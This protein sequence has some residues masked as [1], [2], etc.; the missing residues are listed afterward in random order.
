MILGANSISAALDRFEHQILGDITQVR[1]LTWTKPC[2]VEFST[3]QL[4]EVDIKRLEERLPK[5]TRS[6]S[7]G[8]LYVFA[9]RQGFLIERSDIL[10]AFNYA[11]SGGGDKEKALNNLCGV[12]LS[13]VPE[14]CVLYVGRSWAPRTRVLNHLR[15]SKSKTYA[16]HFAAWA[17]QIDLKV[18][19]FVFEF[20]SIPDRVL[21]VL[22]DVTWDAL[23]P[24]FGRHGKK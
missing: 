17:Q 22:E 9:Q 2:H 13:S 6:K 5:P 24:L 3:L 8:Y 21:Q 11:K 23:V 18:D 4:S 7:V 1:N 12:N 14:G 16:I 19:L 15:A 10:N 20:P